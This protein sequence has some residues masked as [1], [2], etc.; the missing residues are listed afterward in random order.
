VAAGGN[1][2]QEGLGEAGPRL[3]IYVTVETH[4]CVRR[5]AAMLGLGNR[6]LH[7]VP[8]DERSRMLPGAL[9]SAIRADVAAGLLP[10]AV[11]ATAG[12]VMTGAIEPLDTIADV[13][14]EEGVWLH[15]DGAFGAILAI[16]DKLRPLLRGLER[17][18]SLAFDLHKW[19][20][21]PYGVGCAFIRDAEAHR[22]SFDSDADYLRRYARGTTAAEWAF[23]TLGPE[24]SRGFRGLPVWMSMRQFGIDHFARVVEQNVDQAQRMAELVRQAPELELLDE[25]ALNVVCFRFARDGLGEAELDRINGEILV[26]LQEEGTA[27]PNPALVGGKAGLRCA[28][29]NHR[30]RQG[31]LEL[32]V[33]EAGRLGREISAGQI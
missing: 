6:S 23:H 8:T 26:A 4:N 5:A 28:I 12:T 11:V 33:A 7:F 30:T 3:R 29:V 22:R 2:V 32:L 15:V 27:V 25:P 24:L 19:M 10:M 21:I 9:S 16:S 17:A 31:D 13:C 1:V 20:S 18:D 14:A